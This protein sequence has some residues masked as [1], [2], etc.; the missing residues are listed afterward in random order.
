MSLTGNNIPGRNWKN[1]LLAHKFGVSANGLIM[2]FRRLGKTATL[3]KTVI[4]ARLDRE[5][6]REVENGYDLGE[7]EVSAKIWRRRR[8][9]KIMR[10][11][12]GKGFRRLLT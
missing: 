1:I 12:G 10:L 11:Q 9:R 8:F 3:K 5:I 4:N 2:L 6:G 7:E